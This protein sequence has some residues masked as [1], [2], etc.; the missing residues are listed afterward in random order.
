ML[1]AER[2]WHVLELLCPEH[3]VRTVYARSYTV[4]YRSSTLSPSRPQQQSASKQTTYFPIFFMLLYVYWSWQ[5]ARGQGSSNAMLCCHTHERMGFF[6][7]FFRYGTG[8]SHWRLKV[9]GQID[10][11]VQAEQCIVQNFFSNPQLHFPTTPLSKFLFPQADPA[12]LLCHVFLSSPVAGPE[13]H[14]G[15]RDRVLLS[16]PAR[17]RWA[18]PDK[19]YSVSINFHLTKDS[20]CFHAHMPIYFHSPMS[21]SAKISRRTFLSLP[22]DLWARMPAW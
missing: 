11:K 18:C 1:C 9:T 13:G 2:C 14:Q 4:K 10:K 20:Y 17:V 5:G 22:E 6:R 21:K 7:W 12:S 8:K 16:H 3:I 19:L 15:D